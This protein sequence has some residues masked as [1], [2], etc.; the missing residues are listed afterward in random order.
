LPKKFYYCPKH[1]E[2]IQHL[3]DQDPQLFAEDIIESLVKQFEDFS[4]SQS[5][6]NHYLRNNIR[7]TMKKPTF[8]AEIKNSVNNLNTGFEWFMKWKDTNIHYTKNCV[9]INEAGFNINMSAVK[10]GKKQLTPKY[11]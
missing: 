6:L 9:F 1:E 4:I 11:D 7:I 2:Y 3:I 8:E 10:K 5:R